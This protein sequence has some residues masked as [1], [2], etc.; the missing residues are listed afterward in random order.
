MTMKR[1]MNHLLVTLCAVGLLGGVAGCAAQPGAD[2]SQ[3]PQLTADE[4]AAL[5]SDVADPDHVGV[6]LDDTAPIGDA[7]TF[8]DDEVDEVDDEVVIDNDDLLDD[9][10]AGIGG[11]SPRAAILRSGLHPR[12]SDALRAAG[13]TAA[14]ITQT[15]GSAAASAGTHAA[16]GTVNGLA[17]C[18]ATDISVRELSDTQI[19]N[20]LSRLAKVGFIAWFRFPGHDGWPSS[21]ARHIH[22]VYANSKMKSS[23]RSQVR[24]W[25]VHRNGLVSNT[26]Y[27]FYTW[28]AEN[29][30]IIRNKFVQSA[31]GTTNSGSSCVVGGSYCGG[32][33]IF[34]DAN[35]LY[36]CTGEGAPAKLRVCVNGCSVN[37]GR[38]DSCR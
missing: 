26:I 23:L 19:K 16:D 12:A 7:A 22:A 28:S 9:S 2:D 8:D 15:I 1:M 30:A 32:D 31:S 14:R 29:V 36:R 24:S 4:V 21:E 37:T 33:K 13:V 11:F 38:D 3:D 20:L 34:G 35:T 27:T 25:L 18:S 17:Y 6:V 5:P 10:G